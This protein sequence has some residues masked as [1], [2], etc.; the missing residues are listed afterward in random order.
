MPFSWSNKKVQV[1]IEQPVESIQYV[2][3]P[4]CDKI[5]YIEH[6]NGERMVSTR[7]KDDETHEIK[8]QLQKG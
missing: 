6:K 5:S 3:I 7:E 2:D 1:H 4:T 8:G